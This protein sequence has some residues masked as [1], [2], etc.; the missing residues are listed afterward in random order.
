[1]GDIGNACGDVPLGRGKADQSACL[2]EIVHLALLDLL[3]L[4]RKGRDKAVVLEWN[5]V[6]A[7]RKGDFG[8]LQLRGVAVDIGQFKAP[9]LKGFQDQVLLD[10]LLGPPRPDGVFPEQ[11][12]P[13]HRR[14]PVV[15]R[16]QERHA[17]DHILQDGHVLLEVALEFHAELGERPAGHDGHLLKEPRLDQGC[18]VEK[19]KVGADAEGLHIAGGGVSAPG[20][21]AYGPGHIPPAPLVPVAGRLLGTADDKIDVRL[22]QL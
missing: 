14:V 3:L 8:V 7:D 5:I 18:R 20:H 10:T 9:G 21:F 12:E 15:F 2:N 22:F 1:M 4:N 19:G 17:P 11:V 6:L 16:H 13:E